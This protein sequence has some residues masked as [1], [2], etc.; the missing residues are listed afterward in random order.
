MADQPEMVGASDTP[1]VLTGGAATTRLAVSAPR[2]P[3]AARRAAAAAAGAAAEPPSVHLNIENVTGLD[4]EG[5]YAVYVNVP[6]GEKPEDHPELFAGLVPTFGVAEAT[7]GDANHPAGEGLTFSLDITDVV[8]RL[9]G[10]GAW[11]NEVNVTFVPEGAPVVR[12]RAAAAA[13]PA[14]ITVGRVSLYFA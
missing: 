3:A 6:D 13:A 7:R 8:R 12:R 9:E 5:T 11:T 14:P 4:A 1:I 2:G 10:S